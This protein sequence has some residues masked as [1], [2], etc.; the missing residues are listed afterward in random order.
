[1]R[2]IKLLSL[3]LV[4]L[5]CFFEITVAAPNNVGVSKRTVKVNN[6]NKTVNLVMVD[7]NSS[8]IELGV[9]IAND[10]IGTSEDFLSIIKRNNAVAA[11]N[12]NFFDAYDTLEPY[13]TIMVDKEIVFLED[14]PAY[15]VIDDNG[16]V[17]IDNYDII[18]NG[19]LDGQRKNLWNAEKNA[20]DFYL[21]KIWYV[22]RLPSDPTGVYLYTRARGEKI[23][24]NGGIAIEVRNGKVAKITKNA[25]EAL[26]PKDGYIIY[27]GNSKDLISYVDARF[28][29]GKIVELEYEI[30]KPIQARDTNQEEKKE[31]KK[32]SSKQTTLYGCLNKS[33][34]NYWSAEK[35]GMEFNLF[36]VWYINN[37]PYDTKGVYLYTP[38]KGDKLELDGGH[39]V[40]VENGLV[41][42]VEY[43]VKEV[44]I[45]KNGFVIY[46]GKDYDT[47][48]YI[49]NRF[50][51]GESVDFYHKDTL[52]IDTQ[53]LIS[54]AVKDNEKAL[55]ENAPIK[56]QE[57][58]KDIQNIKGIVSAG[59]HLVKDGKVIFD[60]S[61]SQIKEDKI[62]KARGQR[63]AV[64]ITKN[65]K[66][67]MVT[68]SNLNMQELAQI[69]VQLGATDAMALDGGASSG[70]YAKGSM[71]TK[72]GRKLSTVL[73]VYDKSMMR[74]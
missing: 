36:Q 49:A 54:K 17:D 40:T 1:M 66:L 44:K 35:N 34:R 6:V 7:L 41:A 74:K 61:K 42:K 3:A 56:E 13:G 57:E 53:N 58:K 24:L 62:T 22:N 37:Y 9:K 5:F 59:P 29:V 60:P 23:K 4:F 15:M 72:P 25:K 20:M 16:K 32:L 65:N 33:T 73:L 14:S 11:I 2:K 31:E 39:A 71:I 70:L 46:Y 68:G 50:D 67:L 64:G 30:K 38:E 19:Y 69:M 47:R 18:I 28:K 10:K 52:K 51:L 55:Y 63:S 48:D 26:I 45:P 27:Y 12:G 8:D 43:D 21:F